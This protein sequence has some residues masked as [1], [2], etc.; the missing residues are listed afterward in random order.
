MHDYVSGN[1]LSNEDTIVQFALF[2][3]SD[4]IKFEDAVTEEK[5]KKAMDIKIQA[6]ERNDIWEL[7][8]LPKG[9]KTIGVKWVYNQA[10]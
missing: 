10:E 7:T 6:I 4:P 1:E 5:W 9:Q 8:D 2:A 3:D